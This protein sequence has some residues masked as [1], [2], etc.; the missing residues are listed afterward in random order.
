[1][2]E[3]WLSKRVRWLWEARFMQKEKFMAYEE[4][5]L[6]AAGELGQGK[7][8][9]RQRLELLVDEKY[10]TFH[11]SLVPGEDK[12]M[13]VRIPQLR[14]LARELARGDWRSYLAE[15]TEETYEETMLQGLV[16]GYAKMELDEAYV[17]IEDFVPKI[18]NWA[19]CDCVCSTLKIVRRDLGR[20]WEFLQKYLTDDR[21][22]FIR[23]GVIMLL[24]HFK[25]EKEYLPWVLEALDGIH[26]DAYY[27]KMAVA[28][29]LSMYYV[30]YPKE[31]MEYFSHHHLD[32][33]TYQKTLQKIIE[34]RQ[35][36]E[37]TREQIREMKRRKA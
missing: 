16:I 32:D 10:K 14:A 33:F 15:A 24:D 36:S 29:A 18:R 1:M 13:G 12:I 35:I 9:I 22:Y 6:S 20:T 30:K 34:S 8:P 27:V 3:S 19:V 26:H 11:S 21:E 23:F 5:E 7:N 2:V 25:Q 4:K 31:V 17:R 37:E 28:W